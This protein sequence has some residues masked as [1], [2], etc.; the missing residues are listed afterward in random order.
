MTTSTPSTELHQATHAA[1]K[2]PLA[3]IIAGKSIAPAPGNGQQVLVSTNPAQ[4][5]QTVWT[6]ACD[7][8]HVEAAVAAARE[9]LPQWAS[10]PIEQRI[11]FLRIYQSL[12]AERAESIGELI[13]A[14][15]GKAIW[16][17][18][19]EAKLLGAK[20][21]ITLDD[22]TNSGR[23]RV[24]GFDIELSR[25]RKGI[26]RFRPHGVMAVVGP[27]NFPA[28]LPN[29]H[30]VPALLTGN[31]IVFKP[32]DKTPAVGQALAELFLE[33]LEQAGAQAGVFNLIQGRA[34]VASSLVSHRGVDGVLFTG[35]WPVGRRILEANLDQPGKIIAL[36]M[37][38]NNPAIIMP[39]ADLKQ[40]AIEC[41]RAAFVTTGQRCTCTRRILVHKDIVR[42]FATLLAKIASNLIV[43]DPKGI[44][45]GSRNQPVF[46]GPLISDESRAQAISFQ[47]DL[48]GAKVGNPRPILEMTAIEH[49]SGGH[50]VSPGIWQV[51]AFSLSDSVASDAGA[52][53][54]LFGPM[55]R[56]AEFDSLDEAIEQANTTRYGLAASIFTQ[57]DDAIDRFVVE[58]RAGCININTG[59][60]GASGKLPFGG[61]GWSGNHRPAGAFSPDYC[62]YPIASMIEREPEVSL[63]PGMHYEDSWI[64]AIQ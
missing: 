4:P 27:F 59:T 40:A 39:D 34:E 41:A 8:A 42:P 13:C 19:A 3:D 9:A 63:L 30:I 56:I 43:G 49:P 61:L 18:A 33:A 57:D 64:P 7:P 26:C 21:D 37:G 55:V 62:A 15:T 17:S 51:D 23:S 16:D 10:T 12:A 25:T 1:L 22:S 28:H 38:G 46:M 35:S 50:Y 2:R 24:T 45:G 29:G 58:A 14:E 53:V 11:E 48:A 32:S 36:E 31:T 6:G 52:D 44:G 20:V 47:R 60:A 5:E 54:E